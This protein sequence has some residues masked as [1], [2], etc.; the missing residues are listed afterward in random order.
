MALYEVE[1]EFMIPDGMVRDIEAT[2]IEDAEFKMIE[3]IKG[4]AGDDIR[5]I[6]VLTIKEV[7]R[8]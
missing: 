3:L 8:D 5:N 1:V 4:E 6:E 7:K 2:S